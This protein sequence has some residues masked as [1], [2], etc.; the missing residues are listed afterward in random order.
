N[1]RCQHAL[2]QRAQEQ[3]IGNGTG[4]VTDE[5]ART[6]AS[7]YQLVQRR[8]AHRVRQRALDG[9]LRIL[10]PRQGF[11]ADDGRLRTG[12]Q[13]DLDARAPVEHVDLPGRYVTVDH[14]VISLPVV[15][16]LSRGT[17]H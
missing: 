9:G 7:P 3:M 4:D 11:L 6:L 13:I 2:D 1:P 15:S 12:R 16:V 8:R 5:D 17:G 10:M 14:E